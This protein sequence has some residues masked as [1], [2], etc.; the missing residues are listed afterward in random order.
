M[1]VMR[2]LSLLCWHLGRAK[3]IK[4][5]HLETTSYQAFGSHQHRSEEPSTLPAVPS[6]TNPTRTRRPGVAQNSPAD[7][8]GI[9]Q[10][11]DPFDLFQSFADLQKSYEY[12]GGRNLSRYTYKEAFQRFQALD[13]TFG[14]ID[15][16]V[17]KNYMAQYPDR[18]LFR[19]LKEIADLRRN[20]VRSVGTKNIEQRTDQSAAPLRAEGLI[21]GLPNLFRN[22]RRESEK[23]KQARKQ[24][25]YKARS[26]QL[27][28]EETK[29][30]MQNASYFVKLRFSLSPN[31]QTKEQLRVLLRWLKLAE[32]DKLS[33]MPFLTPGSREELQRALEETH[34]VKFY[35]N[36]RFQMYK[37]ICIV[38]VCAFFAWKAGSDLFER[39]HHSKREAIL[40][41]NQ[42]GETASPSP[43]DVIAN[44]VSR[45]NNE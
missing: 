17:L 14:R 31:A 42:N 28:G 40:E 18:T 30:A 6:A 20:Y 11:N 23:W 32:M 4:S 2:S 10:Q 21:A 39:W 3:P 37:A 24:N 22:A 13:A 7:R 19:Q 26:G 38:F 45:T 27:L 16:A 34:K 33:P 44:V 1:Y 35:S 36:K 43:L 15:K 25:P 12:Y 41:Q 5:F 8:E 29:R 9:K